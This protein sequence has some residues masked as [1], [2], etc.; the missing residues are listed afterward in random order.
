MEQGDVI[1]LGAGGG[2]IGIFI[3]VLFKYCYKKELHTKCKSN[4]C[5]SSIDIEDNSSP[6]KINSP[7][8]PGK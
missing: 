5:E 7:G 6:I 4:C 8:V 2:L 1:G 3:Y